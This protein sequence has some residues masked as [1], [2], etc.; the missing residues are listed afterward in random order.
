MQFGEISPV[1]NKGCLASQTFLLEF[2]CQMLFFHKK[3]NEM[4]LEASNPTSEEKN[5]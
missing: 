4:I 1:K 3:T 5:S 2:F